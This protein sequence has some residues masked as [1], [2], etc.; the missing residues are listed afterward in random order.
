LFTSS[1]SQ[2]GRGKNALTT[3]IVGIGSENKEVSHSKGSLK[4]ER[5]MTDCDRY[6]KKSE[7]VFIRVRMLSW[8]PQN[9]K[10]GIKWKRVRGKAAR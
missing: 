8:S 9:L 3:E 10:K 7:S 5:N 2:K 6:Q 4:Q 1:P